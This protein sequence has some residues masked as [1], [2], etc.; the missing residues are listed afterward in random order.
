MIN[1]VGSNQLPLPALPLPSSLAFFTAENHW[2]RPAQLFVHLLVQGILV[3]RT[4]IIHINFRTNRLICNW[5]CWSGFFSPIFLFFHSRS[6]LP[7]SS[8]GLL[9]IHQVGPPS[10]TL[11]S[12]PLTPFN[13]SLPLLLSLRIALFL[14]LSSPIPLSHYVHILI[15]PFSSFSAISSIPCFFFF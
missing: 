7:L 8:T 6:F 2:C 11:L 13:M 5:C 1:C 14:H 15:G 12:G 4:Q 9:W 10:S 3:L